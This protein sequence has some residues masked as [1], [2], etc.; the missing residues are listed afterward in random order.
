MVTTI[1]PTVAVHSSL[2]LLTPKT[3]PKLWQILHFYVTKV[4]PMVLS[5][6]MFAFS[7]LF[8]C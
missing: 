5:G 6:P 7:C 2:F 8:F 3:L 1:R 4:F